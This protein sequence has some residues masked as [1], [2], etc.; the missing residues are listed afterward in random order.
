MGLGD[1]GH[2]EAHVG[3]RPHDGRIPARRIKLSVLCCAGLHVYVLGHTGTYTLIKEAEGSKRETRRD[4]RRETR[5]EIRQCSRAK[6]AEGRGM[7]EPCDM[8]TST[9]SLGSSQL[10]ANPGGGAQG[11]YEGY[12]D[13]CPCPLPPA[14]FPSPE[15]TSAHPARPRTVGLP[16]RKVFW[17]KADAT[18]AFCTGTYQWYLDGFVSWRAGLLFE[19]VTKQ[20]TASSAGRRLMH[21]T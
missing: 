11:R 7:T 12:I 15:G 8:G 4:G 18:R 16:S 19:V 14:P 10:A 1:P 20:D 21:G 3:W 9:E 17:D 2:V 5:N 6:P 13:P